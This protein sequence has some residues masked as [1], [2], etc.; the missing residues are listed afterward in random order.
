MNY[1]VDGAHSWTRV[2][3]NQS[4][5]SATI[6]NVSNAVGLRGRRAGQQRRGRR[7]RVDELRAPWAGLAG[8]ATVSAVKGGDYIEGEVERRGRRH[9]V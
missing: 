7:R 4:A 5:T 3:S 9:R 8:P 2:S 6:P 1:T